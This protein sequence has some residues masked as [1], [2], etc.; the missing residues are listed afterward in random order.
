MRSAIS[1]I[2]KACRVFLLGRTLKISKVSKMEQRRGPECDWLMPGRAGPAPHDAPPDG[3][4]AR[5]TPAAAVSLTT[6]AG[7]KKPKTPARSRDLTHETGS[8]PQDF[9]HTRA[10]RKPLKSLRGGCR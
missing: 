7:G 2:E 5:Q 9:A 3:P 8:D 6:A 1:S 4:G 10:R